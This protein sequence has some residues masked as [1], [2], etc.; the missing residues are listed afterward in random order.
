MNRFQLPPSV[1]LTSGTRP[2]VR[3][4]QW[5]LDR[6]GLDYEVVAAAPSHITVIDRRD[7][8]RLREL[9]AAALEGGMPAA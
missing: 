5:G 4:V 9:V 3:A 2:P 7:G 1:P 8:R 6:A